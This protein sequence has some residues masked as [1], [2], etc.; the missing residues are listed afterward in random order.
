MAGNS[1][2]EAALSKQNHGPGIPLPAL[3]TAVLEAKVSSGMSDL[4]PLAGRLLG[5][6]F[7][8]TK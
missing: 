8:N 5:E 7:T 1:S 4:L 6:C 3:D 2:L